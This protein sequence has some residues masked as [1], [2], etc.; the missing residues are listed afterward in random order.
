MLPSIEKHVVMIHFTKRFLSNNVVKSENTYEEILH[1]ASISHLTQIIILAKVFKMLF[2]IKQ[3]LSTIRDYAQLPWL[4]NSKESFLLQLLLVNYSTQV[5]LL[6][7]FNY[8]HQ[9]VSL[10]SNVLASSNNLL[11]IQL[12]FTCLSFCSKLQSN[13]QLLHYW[14]GYIIINMVT[15]KPTSLIHIDN[16]RYKMV[17]KSV[18]QV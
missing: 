15:S 8:A 14:C 17:Q 4:V 18:W 5:I 12:Y 11:G 10:V 6:C 1:N 2:I 7:S 16:Y 3:S 13:K 9:Q